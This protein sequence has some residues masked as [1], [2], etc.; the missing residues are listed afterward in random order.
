[1]QELRWLREEPKS[2]IFFFIFF[3]LFFFQVLCIINY[4][5]QRLRAAV[6]MVKKKPRPHLSTRRQEKSHQPK[7]LWYKTNRTPAA[8]KKKSNS[9]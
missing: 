6:A 3:S 1:M 8:Q 7:S 5:E 4:W 2:S 9:D